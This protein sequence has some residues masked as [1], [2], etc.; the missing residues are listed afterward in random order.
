M[1]SN[2]VDPTAPA[3]PAGGGLSG[4]YPNP[5]V[6]PPLP[7]T[8]AAAA[9]GIL[10]VTDTT[11]APTDAIVLVIG[12]GSGD[13]GVGVR[14]S[15]D[16]FSRLLLGTDGSVKMSSGSATADVSLIRGAP[17]LMNLSLA[18]LGVSTAGRGLRVAE[19]ANAKQGT[20]VLVGG[21]ATVA[22]TA[23]TASSRIFLTSQ[24]DGGAPGFLRVSSRIAGTSFTI[25]SSSGTDTSTVAYEI[26][27]P[28]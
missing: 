19:G 23:V 3:G 6:A 2:A 9:G 20:A 21:S 13:R 10:T 4:T 1:S 27:E 26:F 18:D 25:T 17:N 7:L 24:L 8:Q 22:D 28:G 11:A 16:T 12:A 14:V 5:S 15:G